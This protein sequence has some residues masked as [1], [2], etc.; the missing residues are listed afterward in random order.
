MLP[1][2]D[3]VERLAK[4]KERIHIL[5]L[6][7]RDLDEP[8]EASPLAIDAEKISEVVRK[9]MDDPARRREVYLTFVERIDVFPERIT[10]KLRVPGKG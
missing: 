8:S 9:M 10:V 5:E 7:L 1:L 2:A 4:A 6:K 3:I